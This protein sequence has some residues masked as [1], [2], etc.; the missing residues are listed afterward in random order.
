[1]K[2]FALILVFITITL[3]EI[4]RLLKSKQVKEA[5]VSLTLISLG[6]ILSLLQVVGIKVLNPNK[7]IIILIKFI[8]P[9]I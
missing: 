4:P 5:V 2:V 6:F 1:M 8:F 3:I 7:A 9:D